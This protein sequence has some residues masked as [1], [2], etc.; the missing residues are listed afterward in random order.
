MIF[1]TVGSSRLPF[2]R[3]LGAVDRLEVDER[4]VVQHGVS[5][6][7]PAHAECVDF[8]A[9]DELV[10]HL[11]R[12]RVVVTHAG[13]GSILT[14]LAE[15]RRP[16]VVARRASLGESV[17][18]HQVAFA[19]RMAER[20]MV[21][22]VDDVAILPDLIVD[23]SDAEP[24]TTAARSPLELELRAYIEESVGPGCS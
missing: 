6:I 18:D 10:E 9:F 15:R 12:A 20:R 22:V 13:V 11:R 17:D 16:L 4:V 8:L 24:S 14:C 5:S 3:L 21:D 1:V 2:D 23:R 19:R 7:A